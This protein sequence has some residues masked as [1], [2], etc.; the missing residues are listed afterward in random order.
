LETVKQT[1]AEKILDILVTVTN[2]DEFKCKLDMNLF[3]A[4]I[5]DS[6]AMVQ[7][8]VALTEEFGMEI[9]P[10]EIEREEWATAN[11]IIAYVDA[12]IKK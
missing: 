12:H 10:A 5:L 9:S 8:M 6:L 7:L 11:K 2:T 4:G 1:T 3:D